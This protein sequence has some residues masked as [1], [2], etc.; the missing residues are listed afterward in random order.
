MPSADDKPALLI[1]SQVHL[2]FLISQS[3]FTFLPVLTTP[4]LGF[5]LLLPLTPFPSHRYSSPSP[6]HSPERLSQHTSRP[7]PVHTILA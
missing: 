6:R 1:Q 5:T 2:N 7:W 3:H 4:N